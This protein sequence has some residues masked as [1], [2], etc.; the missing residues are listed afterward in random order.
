MKIFIGGDSWGLGELNETQSTTGQYY[1]E[2]VHSGIE[3]YFIDIGYTVLNSSMG[4][5]SNTF[6]ISQL[7]NSLDKN[8]NSGDLIFWIKTDPARNLGNHSMD[9]IIREK[10]LEE[11]YSQLKVNLT[12]AIK[13]Y[14]GLLTA[15]KNISEKDY[16]RL[17]SIAVKH[18]TKIYLI[19][20]HCPIYEDIASKFLSLEIMTWS[21]TEL[22][23]SN[24]IE[25]QGKFKKWLLPFP[26]PT[27]SLSYIELADLEVP[28]ASKVLTELSE[29]ESAYNV[30]R[31]DIWC[32][33]KVH[34]NRKGHQILFDFIV[35][36]FN[37]TKIK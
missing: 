6:S 34:L 30:L 12:N 15:L 3:Q 11:D 27:T 16:N 17:N 24:F 5:A 33:D 23:L 28:V 2:I 21:W 13:K 9:N 19:G 14:G 8:Y 31:E 37:L 18:N 7:E 22:I 32:N 4:G 10:I 29:M 36:R 26:R 1:H 25:Y 20:G 35:K